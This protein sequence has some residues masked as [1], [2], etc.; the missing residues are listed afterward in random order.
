MSI[1]SKILYKKYGVV[2]N[3]AE[4]VYFDFILESTKNLEKSLL[5]F[6]K[7]CETRYFNETKIKEISKFILKE[8]IGRDI[9]NSES[10]DGKGPAGNITDAQLIANEEE[11]LGLYIEDTVDTV[12]GKEAVYLEDETKKN[13]YKEMEEDYV[14]VFTRNIKNKYINN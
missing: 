6:S 13:M 3:K 5:S 9:K 7:N 10:P 8:E 14:H 1:L 12:S 11:G 4:D 2:I